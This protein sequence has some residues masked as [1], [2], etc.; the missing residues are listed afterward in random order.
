M[1]ITCI[2]VSSIDG[3]TTQWFNP[4]LHVWTSKEDQA[5]F[6]QLIEQA[7]LIIMGRKTYE[8]AKPFMKHHP[9]RLRIVLTNNPQQFSNEAIPNQLEFTSES[10]KELIKRLEQQGQTNALFVGGGTINTPFF[11]AGLVNELWLTLEPKLFGK[12]NSIVA[13]S[14]LNVNL[15]LLSI[16][17]LNSQGALLLKYAVE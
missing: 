7:Q 13:E 4:H 14:E 17:K 9:G 5:Y 16:E 2:M 1:K 6:A 12:G 3:K 10:A 11:Q 15:E 8:V